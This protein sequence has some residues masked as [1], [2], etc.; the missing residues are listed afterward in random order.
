MDIT[1]EVVIKVFNDED[2]DFYQISPDPD[3]LDCVEV[4]Y[5][6]ETGKPS[7]SRLTMPPDMALIV[8]E[9]IIE[10]SEKLK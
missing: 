8:A 1:K 10:M 3:G 7:D 2:G 9:A 5:F 4:R 6:D